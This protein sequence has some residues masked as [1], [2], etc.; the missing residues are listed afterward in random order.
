MMANEVHFCEIWCVR[1]DSTNVP[2]D[3]DE[4]CRN[5]SWNVCVRTV[6]LMHATSFF[7]S[8]FLHYQIF[9]TKPHNLGFCG[10][11]NAA[12]S[13]AY[14]WGLCWAS[15]NRNEQLGKCNAFLPSQLG[16]GRATQIHCAASCGTGK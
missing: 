5:E 1:D 13:T 4:S 2:F 11:H 16:A 12:F 8:L 7:F 9:C 14:N 10:A 15:R 6:L 3:E